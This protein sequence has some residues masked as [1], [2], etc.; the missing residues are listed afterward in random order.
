MAASALRDLGAIVR[1]FAVCA[2]QDDNRARSSK[3]RYGRVCGGEWPFAHLQANVNSRARTPQ[4]GVPTR[5]AY[6]GGAGGAVFG[7]APERFSRLNKSLSV[8]RMRVDSFV[9]TFR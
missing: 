6:R 2:A 9:S 4:R 8:E 3:S 7:L 5:P 1:S